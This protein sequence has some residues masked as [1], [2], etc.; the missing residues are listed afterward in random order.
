MQCVD[1][2]RTTSFVG[3]VVRTDAPDWVPLEVAIGSE[4]AGWFMWMCEIRLV[5][6]PRLHAYKHVATRRYLH[7]AEDCRAFN[8][9]GDGRYGEVGL[10][11][12]IVRA[13]SGWERALPSPC[14]V[15]ALHAAVDSAR[16]RSTPRAVRPTHVSKR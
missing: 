8:Y 14:H 2:L 16:K 7:I 3:I 11:S 13:F 12:A 4:I 6:G 9:F 5:D 15:R 10:A 1:M